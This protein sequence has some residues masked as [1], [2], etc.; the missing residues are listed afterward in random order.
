MSTSFP[1]SRSG[2]AL[3]VHPTTTLPAVEGAPNLRGVIQAAILANFA[4]ESAVIMKDGREIIV[5]PDPEAV[6]ELAAEIAEAISCAGCFKAS[7]TTT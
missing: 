2:A 6:R 7:E 4:A 5:A 3:S 1:R